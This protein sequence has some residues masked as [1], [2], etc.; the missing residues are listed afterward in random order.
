MLKGI[1]HVGIIVKNLDEAVELYQRL[2]GIEIIERQDWPGEGMKNAVLKIG[3]Q[4]FEMMDAYPGRP[5]AKFI[6]QHG[7]GI[8]HVNLMVNDLESTVNSLKAKGATVIGRNNKF[9]FIHP[10]STKGVL[11]ELVQGD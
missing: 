3:E 6:E 2:F 5:L 8:H 10:K 4:S 9:A 7:E 1:G 11:I